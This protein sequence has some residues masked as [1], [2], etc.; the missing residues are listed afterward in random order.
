MPLP[1]PVADYLDKLGRDLAFDPG[2]SRRVRREVEDHLREAAIAEDTDSTIDAE[3][4]AIMRFGAPQKIAEQYRAIS[5]HTRLKKTGLLVLCAILFVFGAMESRVVWYGLTRWE[6][7]AHLKN[8][9]ETIVPIDHSAFLL[10][11]ILGIVGSI[12]AH[13]PIPVAYEPASRSR[14]RYGQFLIAAAGGATAV[15]VTCEAILTS[16]RL[17]EARWTTSS[18]LPLSSIV[19]EIGIILAAVVY[20]LNTIRRASAI[21]RH[22]T[23]GSGSG[24]IY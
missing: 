21:L 4:R 13:R 23:G 18:I 15:A 8:V 6:V 14:I 12:I 2:L 11:I 10:A 20:I 17:V 7:G 16:W 3:N 9:G 19:I 24:E 5:L 22:E 1:S